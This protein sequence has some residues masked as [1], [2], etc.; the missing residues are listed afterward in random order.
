MEFDLSRTD[1]R[2][3][4]SDCGK[5]PSRVSSQWQPAIFLAYSCA[6]ARDSHPLPCLLPKGKD[7]QIEGLFKERKNWWKESTGREPWKSNYR[8]VD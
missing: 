4:P 7:A 8:H 6:A 2:S 5:M 3:Q 1:Q